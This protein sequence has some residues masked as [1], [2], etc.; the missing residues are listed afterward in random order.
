VRTFTIST[1]ILL[2]CII[3]TL[4]SLLLPRLFAIL[5]AVLLLAW[6][7]LDALLV[8]AGLKKNTYMQDV[9]VGKFS[10]AYPAD[11]EGSD[12]QGQP[13]E[14]GPGAVMILG[15]RSN[16]PLGMFAPGKCCPLHA[17]L[18]RQRFC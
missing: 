6:G 14:N 15:T 1:W 17:K 4:L 2:G 11:G 10:V 5:P 3:Q 9:I 13:G 16:S 7:M 8:Y 18:L 12:I